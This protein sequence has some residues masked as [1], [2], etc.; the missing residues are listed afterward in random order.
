M[1]TSSSEKASRRAFFQTAAAIFCPVMESS[2]TGP[3][4]KEQGTMYGLINKII[5][6]PNRR[7]DLIAIL[8]GSSSDMPGCLSYV[9]GEDAADENGIWVTE[10]WDSEASHQA[11]LSLPGVKDAI[12]KA[13]PIIAGFNK[14]RRHQACLGHPVTPAERAIRRGFRDSDLP[15]CNIVY[16][17]GVGV[18]FTS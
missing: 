9:I 13:R 18:A 4:R 10:I 7:D 17:M 15:S 6:A 11:S 2:D 8:K 5:S 14:S 1:A 16:K 3:S 12:T